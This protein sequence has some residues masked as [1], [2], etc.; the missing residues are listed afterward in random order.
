MLSVMIPYTYNL[1]KGSFS[2]VLEMRVLNCTQKIDPLLFMM[3]PML[4]SDSHV[5]AQRF[6]AG[7]PCWASEHRLV[8][9][10]RQWDRI[11]AGLLL[12][13]MVI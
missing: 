7:A 1:L 5:L 10:Q 8:G 3:F 13:L 2:A 4:P 12:L 11:M 9:S 6:S